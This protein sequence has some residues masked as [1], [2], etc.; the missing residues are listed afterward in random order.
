MIIF[1]KSAKIRLNFDIVF[2]I[3]GALVA[4]LKSTS[5]KFVFRAKPELSALVHCNVRS[6]VSFDQ[7]TATKLSAADS[8]V[9]KFRGSC[10][11]SFPIESITL[12]MA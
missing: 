5:F 4:E 7:E 3:F 12:I 2:R 11:C 9:I 1:S 8:C 6:I 10:Q